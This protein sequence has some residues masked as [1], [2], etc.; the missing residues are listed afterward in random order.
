MLRS[1]VL[2][3]I[4]WVLVA[5]QLFFIYAMS[6][7][8]ASVSSRTSG[9]VAQTVARVLTPDFEQLPMEQQTAI[10]E[11]YQHPTR[12]AAHMVEYAVL[13]GLIA[14]ALS[15]KRRRGFFLSLA[16]AL[17]VAALDEVHQLWVDGRGAL[18]TDVLIDGA[19]ALVGAAAVTAFSR[20]LARRRKT[21]AE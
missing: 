14:L 13:A 6:A 2:R 17:A 21:K 18:V 15:H 4:V 16:L 11:S 3:G 9:Q 12:K 10:V 7:Q 1:R 8:T 20:I 19:G 5:A